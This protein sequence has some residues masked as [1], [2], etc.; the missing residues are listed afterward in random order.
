MHELFKAFLFGPLSDLRESEFSGAIENE[1]H[2]AQNVYLSWDKDNGPVE[3]THDHAQGALLAINVRVEGSPRWF[4]LNFG[5]GGG[6]FDS[7]DVIVMVLKGKTDGGQSLPVFLRS[8][9]SWGLED[10]QWPDELTLTDEDSIVVACRTLEPVDPV[11]GTPG[12][13]TVAINLPKSSFR[14][15][16][17]DM[18][19]LHFPA[20]LG[21]RSTAATLSSEA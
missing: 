6:E 7:G 9:M 17:T 1:S 10:T 20:G 13:H 21:L 19:L 3:V 8:A 5:V 15:T 14:L 12:F 16:I 2:L 18:R 11:C 4:T